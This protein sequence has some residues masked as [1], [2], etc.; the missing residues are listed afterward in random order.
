MSKIKDCRWTLKNKE[1]R[2]SEDVISKKFMQENGIEAYWRVI[3][4]S[5][6]DFYD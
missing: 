3:I 6:K 4:Q 2:I 5:G 1:C